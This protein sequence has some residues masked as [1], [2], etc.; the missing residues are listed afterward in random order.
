M[1]KEY[2]VTAKTKEDLESLYDDLETL[3]GCKCIPSRE[4]ECVYRRP[5]SR[6]THYYLTDEEA[7][8][9]RKDSRV[10]SVELSFKERGIKIKPLATI[11]SSA[12]E[13][14]IRLVENDPN[15]I[16]TTTTW[17]KSTNN[18][19]PHRPW[20]LYR[21]VNGA[22]VSNWGNNGTQSLSGT[23]LFT[24]TG[25]N[26]DVVVVDGCFDPAHPEFAVNEAGTGGSR[27]NQFNWFSLNPTVTGGDAK[28][29]LYS[30]AASY[31]YTVTNSG[32]SSYTFSGSVTGSNPTLNVKQG[33]TLTFAVSAPGHPF[34][35]KTAQVTGT[36]SGVTTGTISNNGIE[37]G[38]VTWN[39]SGVT[40]GT[41]Y[42]I[43]QF[44]S[45]MVGVINVAAGNGSEN[46]VNGSTAQ[47]G[48]NNHGCHVAGTAVGNRRG[49]ARDASIY[50]INPY[51]S[52]PSVVDP[53]LMIDYI[54][55]W[56]NSKPANTTTG[57]RN[58]TITNHSYGISYDVAIS[59][60][61]YV[62]YRGTQYNSPLTAAQL[63]SFGLI[64]DGTTI[65][66]VPYL[67]LAMQADIQDAISDGIIF[68]GAAG[69]SS[70]KID[71]SGG[72][73]Y[74][75]ILKENSFSGEY[76]HRGTSPAALDDVICVGAIDANVVE[77]KATY[78][79][80]GPR[81]DVYAPGSNVVS[82]VH[83]NEG[84]DD[85]RNTAYNI[86]KKN[87]TSMASP[88]VAGVLACIAE[89]WPRMTQSETR[90]FINA[91]NTRSQISLA[92]V[93][94]LDN[95]NPT[96]TTYTVGNSGASDYTFSGSATGNDP[97][98]TVAEG[99][100]M[101]FNVNAT[102]H[103]F[104]IKTSQVTGTGSGVT[105]GTITNN[106]TAV[107]TVTWDTRGVTP[108]TYYYICQFHS[109]MTNT[110][111]ITS[112][113]GNTRSLQGGVSRY[114]FY[115]MIRRVPNPAGT[116]Y[117]GGQTT[118]E[119]T[120]PRNNNK[121]RPIATDGNPDTTTHDSGFVY[122]RHPIWNRSLT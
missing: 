74:N 118:S 6:N 71:V 64:N 68:V 73:D 5:I 8:L 90:A 113:H 95:I 72:V 36:G 22:T 104:W 81:I 1:E 110:I 63:T 77:E 107:G 29:Y 45:S 56:H 20:A 17:S 42:Y 75:N 16:I 86:I 76:Y 119:I 46:Y 35:I 70:F 87:G 114:L 67:S 39:T 32:A 34:W 30:N 83:N 23:V 108:G 88:N 48:D 69:N 13:D 62:T 85:S 54:R 10:L 27:V 33:D 120:F 57:F 55:A 93:G 116:T 51:G 15:Y 106:G 9:I 41:Y 98:I 4:I 52:A 66:D 99:T 12:T 65:Q 37:S 89:Q 105:T 2:I 44:H 97:A 11:E 14:E 43:C 79:N 117:I 84:I 49:W 58:P 53:S 122:P 28:T 115:P 80:C 26:V 121:F 102:G 91:D 47:Q 21:C 59:N 40:A 112:D 103:P 31:S 111:T 18:S 25:K 100:V 19:D 50:N 92:K 94:Q 78:S 38:T 96:A 7:E 60:V 101:T 109:A 61:Q 82:S 24:N 3:G